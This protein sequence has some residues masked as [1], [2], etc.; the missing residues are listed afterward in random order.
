MWDIGKHSHLQSYSS[1]EELLILL[2]SIGKLSAYGKLLDST[3]HDNLIDEVIDSRTV[4]M[5]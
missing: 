5:Y 1:L 4:P 2:A 3:N